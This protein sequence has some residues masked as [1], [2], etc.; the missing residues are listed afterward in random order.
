MAKPRPKFEASQQRPLIAALYLKGCPQSEI[1]AQ[2]NLTQ[3]TV[4]RDLKLIQEQWRQSAISDMGEV[5]QRELEKIDLIEYEAWQAWLRSQADAISETTFGN[6][7]KPNIKSSRNQYGDPRFLAQIERCIELRCKIL[8][9]NAPTKIEV[10]WQQEL[11]NQGIDA[12][13]IFNRLVEY[14]ATSDS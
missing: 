6:S 4:S 9:I 7:D 12:S 11:E 5:K 2:L 3:A 1:A 14:I 10:N 8:G 13:A